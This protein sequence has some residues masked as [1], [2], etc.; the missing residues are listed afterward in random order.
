MKFH[1]LISQ[2]NIPI[3]V[4]IIWRGELCEMIQPVWSSDEAEQCFVLRQAG[5]QSQLRSEKNML[6][7]CIDIQFLFV[8]NESNEWQWSMYFKVYVVMMGSVT[9]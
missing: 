2:K 5:E 7:I 9:P 8:E 4:E 1:D 6:Y 3:E